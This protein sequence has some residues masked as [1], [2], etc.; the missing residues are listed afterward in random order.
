MTFS[1]V[2]AQMDW[3][4]LLDIV[5]RV[6][7]ALCC[8][9]FHELSHGFV[10]WRLGDD[11][12]KKAGRLTLNPLRHIDVMGLL[13]M[14]LIRFG[15]AKPVPVN[16]YKFKNPKRD[17]AITALAGPLSNFLLAF[18]LMLAFGLLWPPLLG[19]AWGEVLLYFLYTTAFLS[20][21]LG[22]FNLV[23]IPPLDGSKI[24]FSF[25]PDRAYE[26][27]MRYERYGMLLFVVL[28]ILLNRLEM[29]PLYTAANFVFDKLTVLAMPD[30]ESMYYILVGR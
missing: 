2:M 20:V 28:I 16:M 7:P 10:A 22:L 29:N 23:P 21:Y 3:G 1:Q 8:I 19:N 5:K 25:L 27:L 30:L 12:A 13:M 9:T 26:R 18:V 11:T 17:M 6:L 4:Y 24:F 14:A 15:W